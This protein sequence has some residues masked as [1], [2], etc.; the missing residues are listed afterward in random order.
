MAAAVAVVVD[1]FVCEVG[2]AAVEVNIADIDVPV[3]VQGF[4]EEEIMALA[5]NIQ[6]RGLMQPIVVR[7]N[8]EG[9][10]EVLVGEQRLE[11]CKRLG[12]HSIPAILGDGG[13][14]ARG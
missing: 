4:E 9:R 6:E 2:G 14:T 1:V 7:R 5:R 10:Y 11:A 3:A 12:W 8:S 13:E